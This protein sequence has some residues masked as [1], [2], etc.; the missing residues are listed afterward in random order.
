MKHK[1][2][3][4]VKTVEKDYGQDLLHTIIFLIALLAVLWYLKV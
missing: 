4:K 2:F 3:E 1:P